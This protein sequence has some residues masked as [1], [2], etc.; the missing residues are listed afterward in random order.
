MRLNDLEY[1]LPPELIAQS[2]VPERDRSRLLAVQRGGPVA[3]H[4]LFCELPDLLCEGDLL[5]LNDTRVLPARLIGR[6]ERTAG[7]WDGLFVRQTE[8][9]V[10]EMLCQTGGK[11]VPGETVIIE[12]ACGDDVLRL[13]MVE[14]TAGGRWLM[15]PQRLGS[16]VD[17]LARFG[18]IPLPPY[19]R[20]GHAESEDRERYQ[21]VYA[22]KAGAV[23]AP[24]AG[25]HFTPG[26]FD[27]L[28]RRGISRTFLTLHVGP[29][30]F[31]PVQTDDPAEH[32]VQAEWGE[33]SENSASIIL[34]TKAKGGR[35]VAV[36]T[37]SVR[38]LETAARQRDPGRAWSGFTDLTICPPFEFR[39]VD[40][41]ITNFHLPRSSLLLL[42][43]AFTGL[44]CMRQ[45]YREA[46]TNRYR[47]YSYGDAMLIQ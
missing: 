9:G 29:G 47:F 22:D 36:G 44:D 38:V 26:L 39:S 16:V 43:A 1:D 30:T 7:K 14:K 8:H 45:A 31:Q 18:R 13:E 4:H 46:I 23:A 28:A 42:V 20:K 27:A 2:P 25:L 17:L 41:L 15:R 10:W 32:R 37:T 35:I 11:P 33:I 24:T 19:I 21:T 40:A 5:V 3:G 6:R 34:A 12:S